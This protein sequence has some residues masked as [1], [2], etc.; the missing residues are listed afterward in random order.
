MKVKIMQR[1]VYH[2]YTE[3]EVEVPNNIKDE[4]VQEYLID[5]EDLYTEI[6]N[7]MSDGVEYEDGSGDGEYEG[8]DDGSEDEWRF[9]IVGK[10]YGG[11]L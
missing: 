2:T 10:N 1:S 7:E 9:D 8:M 6:M 3:V 5:N 11:H 4:D